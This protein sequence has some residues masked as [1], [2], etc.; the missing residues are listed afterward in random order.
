M[1]LDSFNESEFSEKKE[2]NPTYTID[3]VYLF[4]F[5]FSFSFYS[6]SVG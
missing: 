5:L 6:V 4:V 1:N 3:H 2:D